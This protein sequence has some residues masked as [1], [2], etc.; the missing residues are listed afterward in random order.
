MQTNIEIR[1]MIQSDIAFLY[2]GLSGHDV[3]KPLEYVAH[4][5][6]GNVKGERATF[7]ALLDGAFAGWGH[8]VYKP[9]YDDFRMKG[10]PEIQ[11]FDVIPPFRKRGLGTLLLDT[12]EEFAFLSHDVIGIGFG[13]YADYGTAQRMYVKR[14]YIPDGRGVMAGNAP[15]V[16]GS[17]V[18]I[19]DD[20]AIYLTKA[21]PVPAID[22]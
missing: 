16:P 19:D 4:C 6:T 14:G 18:R 8:L 10:I 2:E 20:L 11:N 7:V 12:I 9:Y 17:M 13:L 21:R 15:V 5:W 22:S 1:P 3:A